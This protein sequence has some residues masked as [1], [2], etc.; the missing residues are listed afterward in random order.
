MDYFTNGNEF[1]LQIGQDL[2]AR[3]SAQNDKGTS[4]VS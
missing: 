3:I 4:D 1:S 2:V